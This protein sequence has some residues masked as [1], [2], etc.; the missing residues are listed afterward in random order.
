M[1]IASEPKRGRPAT[2]S[3]EDVVRLAR[4]Q[5]LHG[6]RVDLTVVARRLG[7]GRATIYR[8]FGSR[9]AL[10]GEIIASELEALITAHRRAVRQRGA[11]G[12]LK[13]FDRVNRS[14]SDSRALRALLEQERD[15]ALRLITSSAGHVQPRSVSAV[16]AL[17][18]AE[19]AAG[20]YAPPADPGAL[21]YAIVRLAEAF[22]YNDAAIGIRGDWEALHQVEAALLGVAPTEG[23]TRARKRSGPAPR[24]ARRPAS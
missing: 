20:R 3:R 2:A 13:V 4:S 10:L 19:A 7:L 23:R 1:Q 8:W 11:P 16:R 22:L 6:E 12:L 21:A 17:I 9:D 15:S 5:Y 24:G 18:D 14:L